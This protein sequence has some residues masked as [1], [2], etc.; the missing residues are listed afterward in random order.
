MRQHLSKLLYADE[1]ATSIEE[2]HPVSKARSVTLAK[3]WEDVDKI[4]EALQTVQKKLLPVMQSR[5]LY[6]EVIAGA[7]TAWF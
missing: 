7:Q 1:W 5:Q 3:H 6:D 4:K 2:S